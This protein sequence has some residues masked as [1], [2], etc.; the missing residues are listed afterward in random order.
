[1]AWCTSAW[2]STREGRPAGR[3]HP[4]RGIAGAGERRAA[5]A[6]DSASASRLRTAP[7]HGRGRGPARPGECRP[8]A[9][10]RRRRPGPLPPSHGGEARPA[11]RSG[12]DE[13]RLQHGPAHPGGVHARTLAQ[14]ELEVLEPRRRAVGDRDRPG[15][16]VVG[17]E[18]DADAVHRKCQGAGRDQPLRQTAAGLSRRRDP[19]R[20]SALRPEVT[21]PSCPNAGRSV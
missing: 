20:I 5:S 12:R 16:A 3:P 4:D 19:E 15:R 14:R 11:S 2:S 1:M 17:H 6:N 18:H 9:G 7:P 13:I 21:V 10:G 8:S